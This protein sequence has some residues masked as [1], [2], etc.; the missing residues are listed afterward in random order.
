MI[1]TTTTAGYSKGDPHSTISGLIAVDGLMPGL[2]KRLIDAQSTL[3]EL[4]HRAGEERT[5]L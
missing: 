4:T 3:V 2:A 1:D 5:Q